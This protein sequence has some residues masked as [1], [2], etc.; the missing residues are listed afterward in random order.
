MGWVLSV[1][2]PVRIQWLK[3]GEVQWVV[4]VSERASGQPQKN[5]VQVTSR[6]KWTIGW[7][8]FTCVHVGFVDVPY[9]VLEPTH[10][11]Q[12]FADAKEYRLLLQAMGE[13]MLQYWR[14]IGIGICYLFFLLLPL[15]CEVWL[16]LNI[17]RLCVF[18]ES[19]K[20]TTICHNIFYFL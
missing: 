3:K 14:D 7:P 10:N 9:L 8:M 18:T 1:F 5:F 20:Y 15:F 6:I 2:L 4:S 19:W 17:V 11:K 16:R 12:D 13:H